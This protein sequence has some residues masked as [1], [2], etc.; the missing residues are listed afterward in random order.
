MPAQ[1][2]KVHYKKKTLEEQAAYK[3]QNYEAKK[4]KSQDDWMVLYGEWLDE[5]EL[6]GVHCKFCIKSTL[7][8]AD[9]LSSTGYGFIGEGAERKTAPIPSE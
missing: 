1:A 6:H 9:K 8:A 3:Q 5:D 2:A 4:A 7:K